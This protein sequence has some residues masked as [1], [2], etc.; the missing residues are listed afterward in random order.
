MLAS[1]PSQP[2]TGESNNLRSNHTK[3]SPSA[4]RETLCLD[5]KFL[6]EVRESWRVKHC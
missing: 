3:L 1:V 6:A 5:E 4:P 2:I